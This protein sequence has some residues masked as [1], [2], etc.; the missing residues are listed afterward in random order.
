[1]KSV[2]HQVMALAIT[3][4]TAGG[5][6]STTSVNA[7]P[8]LAL[9]GNILSHHGIEPELS[10]LAPITGPLGRGLSPL[11][12]SLNYGLDPLTDPIDDLLLEQILEALAPLTDPILLLVEP[13]TDPVDGLLHDLTGGSLEDSLTNIDDNTADGNGV[14]NDLLS[15][16]PN[17]ASGTEAGE[18]SALHPITAPLGISLAP[19]IDFLD[20]TLNPLTDAIDANLGFPLLDALAPLTEQLLTLLEPATD[21]VDGILADIT[22]GS[23][24]DALSNQDDNT[25]DGDGIV[26]DLLGGEQVANSGTEA[27][28]HSLLPFVTSPLGEGLAPLIDFLDGSLGSLTDPVDDQVLH[29]LLEALAP[30]TEE[31]LAQLEGVTDPVDGTLADITGGSLE[32]ALSNNDDNTEDGDGVVNDALGGETYANS[33]SEEGEV[34]ALGETGQLLA[35]SLAVLIDGLDM[36]LNP[37]T[38]VVDDQLLEALLDALAP[39]LAPVL[40]NNV[41][42]TDPV[43]EVVGQLSGGSEEGKREGV[44]SGKR[45]VWLVRVSME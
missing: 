2:K 6:M 20:V 13:V 18:Y 41:P 39:L 43:D 21:P 32:D 25:E 7:A 28:E 30:L 31:I 33:G 9:L 38:D 34:S 26:N 17:D 45:V 19:L 22:G 10:P 24:E 3:V 44:M 23:L 37:I 42:V 40:G 12:T 1:M 5:L 16:E 36:G 8:S 14:V 35:D 15:G 11:V 4:F 29:A 27:G